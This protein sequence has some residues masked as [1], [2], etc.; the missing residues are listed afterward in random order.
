MGGGA[1]GML[2]ALAV[3][4]WPPAGGLVLIALLRWSTNG[5]YGLEVLLPTAV[6]MPRTSP[7]VRSR[8]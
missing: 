8:S 1:A 5:T 3:L 7:G 6:T 2:L 4:V